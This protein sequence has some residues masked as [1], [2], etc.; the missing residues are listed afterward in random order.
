M[1]LKFSLTSAK[2]K[3]FMLLGVFTITIVVYVKPPSFQVQQD[4]RFYNTIQCNISLITNR[5][6]NDSNAACLFSKLVARKATSTDPE[7]IQL[8]RYMLDPPSNDTPN[9][10]GTVPKTPQFREIDIIHE[11]KVSCFIVHFLEV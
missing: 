5:F 8:I 4:A 1:R 3:L 10:Q 6:V 9:I 2:H 11:K 7:L